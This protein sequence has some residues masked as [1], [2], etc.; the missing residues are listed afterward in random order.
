MY[1]VSVCICV[2]GEFMCVVCVLSVSC[3]ESLCSLRVCVF[4]L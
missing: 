2:S 3:G 1:D 4:V